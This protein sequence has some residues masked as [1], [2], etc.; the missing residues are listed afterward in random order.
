MKRQPK[1]FEPK[2]EDVK[3]PEEL[4]ESVTLWRAYKR[5]QFRQTYKPL[6]LAQLVE[7]MTAMGPERAMQAVKFSMAQLYQGLCEKKGSNG[8]PSPAPPRL[9]R[10]FILTCL[11]C[12]ATFEGAGRVDADRADKAGWDWWEG[13][14]LC[15]GCK[16]RQ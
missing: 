4:C 3:I 10:A 9:P 8:Q 6:G 2:E 13:G 11:S 1:L 5:E 15:Q 16:D 7:E 12:H 14:A